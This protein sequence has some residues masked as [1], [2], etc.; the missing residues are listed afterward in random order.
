[1]KVLILSA[2][3]PSVDWTN[4]PTDF[5][6]SLS[7]G[8]VKLGHD[9]RV[10]L[11]A[12][13]FLEDDARLNVRPVVEDLRLMW[14]DGLACY[15]N[16][17]SFLLDGTFFYL[18]GN[19]RNFEYAGRLDEKMCALFSRGVIASLRTIRPRWL[20]EV[21]HINDLSPGLA[22]VH[23]NALF[24]NEWDLGPTT[25]VTTV[26]GEFSSARSNTLVTGAHLGPDVRVIQRHS[27]ALRLA[28]DYERIYEEAVFHRESERLAA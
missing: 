6:R 14:E 8:L 15:T 19:S 10:A 12:F 1:M 20:P 16:V 24:L 18:V 28:K 17:Q 9:A 7:R 3:T 25:F 22:A 13:R 23:L 2:E 21:V 4:D 27:S 11:P 26:H 5:V